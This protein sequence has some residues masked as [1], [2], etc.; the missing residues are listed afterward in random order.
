[1]RTLEVS[2]KKILLL[3]TLDGQWR[4]VQ[5]NCP[6]AGA[7]LEQG[8]LCGS[9][10]ICPWHKSCFSSYDG[11]LLESPSLE[12]LR[13][14]SLEIAGDEIRVD[15]ESSTQIKHS[16]GHGKVSSRANQTFAILGG[17]AAASAAVRELRALGFAGRLVMVSQENRAPY[18]RT[19][20]S[21]MY[22]SGQ[23]DLKQLPLRPENWLSDCA[24]DFMVAEIEEVD[25]ESRTIRFKEETIP[26]LRY[27]EALVATGGKPK[28][29]SVAG[30]EAQPF[31]LRSVE[32]ADR[33]IAAAEQSKTAVLIGASFISMEVASALRERGLKVTI[34]SEDNIPLVKRLGPQIGRLLLEKHLQKG[35]RFLPETK[36]LSIKQT[37][38]GSMI[39]LSSNQE[40]R[41]DLVVSGIGIEPATAF[42]KNISRNE[43]H[44]LSVD[45]FM[46]IVGVRRIF[47][48]G[49][50]A[51][52]PLPNSDRRRRIEHWRVAQEQART[53]AANMMGLEKPYKGVPYFWTYHYGVRYEFFGQMPENH[54]LVIDGNLDEPKFVAAYVREGQCEAIFSANRE[55]ETAKLFDQMQWKGTTS[56]QAFHTIVNGR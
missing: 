40:L 42:L 15:P 18:D 41:T 55:S 7:P 4:A 43:D 8:A 50:V 9:R 24:V 1:M 25:P 35:V 44:S 36:V 47:A 49:D 2:D 56:L 33:L 51:N 20:L 48:A 11:A 46:R 3:R 17:G 5:A 28:L 12:S 23:A 6:H 21:K 13:A 26:P 19:L 16:P 54:Q 45:A 27:D 39:K 52:F 29:L 22:L 37:G 38:S 30:A 31:V 34:I 53:A 14:Y 10:L 32:D